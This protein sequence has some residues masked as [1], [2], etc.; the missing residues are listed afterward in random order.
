MVQCTMTS[1][2]AL[3]VLRAAADKY[4]LEVHRKKAALS[5]DDL[6]QLLSQAAALA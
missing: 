5:P 4:S 3:N 2:M 1:A 6:G